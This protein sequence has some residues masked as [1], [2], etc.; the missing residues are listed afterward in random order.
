MKEVIHFA[1]CNCCLVFYFDVKVIIMISVADCIER[2]S[3]EICSSTTYSNSQWSTKAKIHYQSTDAFYSCAGVRRGVMRVLSFSVM[4]YV[5]HE[6]GKELF[7]V[8][9][10]VVFEM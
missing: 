6:C 2:E 1:P 10:S 4:F 7:P 8:V 9:E 3:N 5:D